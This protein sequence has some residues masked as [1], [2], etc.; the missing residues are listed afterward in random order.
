M[1]CCFSPSTNKANT[2]HGEN[3]GY[4]ML[5]KSL[6][7]EIRIH[8]RNVD[9]WTV[10]LAKHEHAEQQAMWKLEQTELLLKEMT[11]EKEFYQNKVTKLHESAKDT[12]C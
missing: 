11:K 8:T 1:C 9:I 6:E 3:R 7:Q 4:E 12:Y 10:K 2:L 5:V